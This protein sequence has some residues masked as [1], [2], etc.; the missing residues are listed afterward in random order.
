MTGIETVHTVADLRAEVA[1]WR[2]RGLRVGLVPTMGAL[3]AGHISL[4]T[5]MLSNADRVVATIFVNPT[6][7]AAGEDL[8]SY[9]RTLVADS[10]KIMAAGGHLVF[11]P[12]VAEV[13][14]DGFATRVKVDGLTDILCGAARPTH[15]D[16][17]TQVVAKLLNMAGADVAIFGEKDWQ[18]LAVIRRMVRDLDIPVH[19]LGGA[20]IRDAFGLALSSRNAYLND[21]ELAVARQLNVVLKKAVYDIG[22]AGSAADVCAQAA[23]TLIGAG[24]RSVDYVECRSAD[25]LALL[26]QLGDAPARIFAAAHIG[27]TRLIDNFPVN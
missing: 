16:G 10:A 12:N 4:I 8:A 20:I 18:Q 24:F 3:H 2:S 5:E 13:Y 25:D 15:F 23:E 17:V 9:P 19:I 1:A 26:D 21:A 27:Q 11:A 22:T 6:Q 7:F 14:P